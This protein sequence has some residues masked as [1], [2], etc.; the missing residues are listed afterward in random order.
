MSTTGTILDYRVWSQ[1]FKGEVDT[2]EIWSVKCW[3]SP[4][5]YPELL[6]EHWCTRERRERGANHQL[7][8]QRRSEDTGR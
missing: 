8:G 5:D 1:L 3:G 2:K 6:S 4:S 7:E